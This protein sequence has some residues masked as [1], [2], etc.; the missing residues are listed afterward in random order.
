MAHAVV[1]VDERHAVALARNADIR[2][3]IDAACANATHILRQSEDAVPLG[4]GQIAADHQLRDDARICDGHADRFECARNEGTERSGIET[5]R[6]NVHHPFL[7]PP[8]LMAATR[9]T[10]LDPPQHACRNGHEYNERKCGG[11]QRRPII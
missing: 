2:M 11:E 6:G 8:A 1:A 10:P 4:S 5:A 9:S 3:E 7:P